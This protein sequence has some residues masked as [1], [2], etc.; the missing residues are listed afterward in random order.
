MK[1][2]DVSKIILKFLTNWEI[3]L[4]EPEKV[5]NTDRGRNLITCLK[6]NGDDQFLSFLNLS[7]NNQSTT[8]AS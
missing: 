6:T 2:I 1:D 4:V 8:L 3:I 5:N 7:V